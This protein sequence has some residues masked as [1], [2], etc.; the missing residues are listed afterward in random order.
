MAE[1]SGLAL[2]TEFT[3]IQQ[4]GCM[5][6][7]KEDYSES[8]IFTMTFFTKIFQHPIQIC[9]QILL[10]LH[11]SSHTR[12]KVSINRTMKKSLSRQRRRASTHQK[13]AIRDKYREGGRGGREVNQNTKW[14][15]QGGRRNQ[16]GMRT[17]SQALWTLRGEVQ[18]DGKI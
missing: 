7:L 3:F 8:V 11:S 13:A 10:R 5:V 2:C 1:L 9:H 18:G 14:Q 4:E 17:Q 12:E 6:T 16:S 15:P